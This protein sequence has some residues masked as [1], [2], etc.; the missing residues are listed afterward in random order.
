MGLYDT[1]DGA[2]AEEARAAACGRRVG[3]RGG[4][5]DARSLLHDFASQTSLFSF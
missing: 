4:A 1:C 5:P 2:W 3:G